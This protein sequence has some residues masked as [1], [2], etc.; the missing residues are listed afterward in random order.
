MEEEVELD[1][2]A[3]AERGFF[4]KNQEYS[5]KAPLY[6]V[7]IGANIN[8]SP[9]SNYGK[10]KNVDVFIDTKGIIRYVIGHFSIKSQAESLLKSL[11]DQGYEDAFVVNVN[12][13]RKYQKELISFNNVNLRGGINGRVDFFVQLGA[14]KKNIP[15]SI[16]TLYHTIEDLKELKYDN[17]TLLLVGPFE[18][19]NTSIEKK[20]ELKK[21]GVNS[22]YVVAFNNRKKV[23]LQEA[24]NYTE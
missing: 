1:S 20:N 24:I 8:P 22:P 13:E 15:D 21:I 11:I 10:V 19:Y 5:T 2:A 4:F 14:F 18:D 9:I 6:G 23:P 16:L 3:L 7:Q 12:N 17:H